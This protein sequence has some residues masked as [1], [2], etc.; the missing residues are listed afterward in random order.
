MRK[1]RLGCTPPM[2]V[3]DEKSLCLKIRCLGSR[4]TLLVDER[5]SLFELA[6]RRGALKQSDH[7]YSQ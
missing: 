3:R 7:V 2:L 5:Q 6:E 4:S 1:H